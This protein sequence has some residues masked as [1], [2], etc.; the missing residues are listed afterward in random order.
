[1]CLLNLVFSE[2][3]ISNKLFHDHDLNVRRHIVLRKTVK[4][5]EGVQHNYRLA[6]NTKK[7]ELGTAHHNDESSTGYL[8]TVTLHH[9]N[10]FKRQCFCQHMQAHL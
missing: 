8:I 5:C 3:A 10:K 4:Y 2:T 1:M 9:A 7:K 6:K